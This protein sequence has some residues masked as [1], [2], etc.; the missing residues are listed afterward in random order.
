MVRDAELDRLQAERDKAIRRK[1]SAYYGRLSAEDHRLN[2]VR[3]YYLAIQDVDRA[4]DSGSPILVLIEQDL[5]VVE[6]RLISASTGLDQLQADYLNAKIECDK[7]LEAYRARLDTFNA[8]SQRRREWRQEV[9]KSA[10]VPAEY[11]SYVKVSVDA[12]DATHVFFGGVG[13]PDGFGHGHYVVE[14]NRAV[15]RR[16]PFRP[17]GPHNFIKHEEGGNVDLVDS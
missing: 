14:N 4:Y 2:A 6:H 17:H 15:Y 7:A 5:E 11:C 3:A 8:E 12:D 16:D 13:S 1:S 9:A 10:G